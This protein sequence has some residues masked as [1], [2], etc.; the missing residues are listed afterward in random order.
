MAAS[1]TR[2]ICSARNEISVLRNTHLPKPK[3]AF[4]ESRSSRNRSVMPDNIAY[5]S[6][7]RRP[8]LTT[9]AMASA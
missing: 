7:T 6:Q 5:D 1:S 8:L 3:I 2:S 4:T 9:P